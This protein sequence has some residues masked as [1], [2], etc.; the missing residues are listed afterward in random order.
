MELSPSPKKI[1]K[2]KFRRI[3]TTGNS[4]GSY[5]GNL[6]G[7]GMFIPSHNPV[8]ALSRWPDIADTE[9]KRFII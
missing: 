2:D 6:V 1:K 8:D 7:T 3:E 5:G 9:I 4:G